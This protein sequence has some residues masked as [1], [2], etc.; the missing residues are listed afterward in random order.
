MPPT[1]YKKSIPHI[2][3]PR[4]PSSPPPAQLSNLIWASVRFA[5]IKQTRPIDFTP[6]RL[7][8]PGSIYSPYITAGGRRGWPTGGRGRRG[9]RLIAS[10]LSPPNQLLSVQPV[11][12][13]ALISVRGKVSH[14]GDSIFGEFQPGVGDWRKLIEPASEGSISEKEPSS[15][16]T[17]G[18]TP[19]ELLFFS[20]REFYR[21]G[22]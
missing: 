15:F 18:L 8:P 13:N 9:G 20:S 21:F 1:R 22:I 17:R 6:C 12:H 2:C 7:L 11:M 14:F 4:P 5:A 19:V 3:S 16:K 10:R